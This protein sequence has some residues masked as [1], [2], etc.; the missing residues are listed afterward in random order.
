MYFIVNNRTKVKN[1]FFP[2]NIFLNLHPLNYTKK[3]SNI[4][5]IT[6][7]WEEITKAEDIVLVA[8]INPDG[9]AIGSLMGMK[10]YLETMGKRVTPIVP[11]PYPEFLSFLDTQKEV[12]AHSE[13]PDAVAAKVEAAQL[14]ICMD[15]NALKRIDNLGDVIAGASAV[16]A[17][18]DHHPQPDTK[19]NIVYSYPQMSST[20][21]L[22]YWIIQ[23][24]MELNG[25]TM[26]LHSAIA[27]YTGMMT[28]T[29]NFGNSV[30]P[31]TFKMAAG[32]MEAG[33]DKEWIQ[34]MVFGGYSA[35][36][37]RL[38]GY[39]LHENMKLIPEHNAAIMVLT[40]AI[41]EKYNFSDGDSEGFVNLALNIKSVKVS[42]L[43][44]EGDEFLRV[45][46]RS[47]DDFSVNRLSRAFFNGGGHERA[48][49]GRLY[50]PAGEV[51]EYFIKS[52]NEFAQMEKQA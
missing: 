41:K 49:G 29:N 4:A 1:I 2:C 23:D 11:N 24:L 8:H 19:F 9:D 6:L 12:M 5:D 10:G 39:M 21:E 13:N 17:L 34:K 40:K 7:L 14:I 31:S 44:T 42:A 15:F 47:K 46:L 48:A 30:L 20:C 38:M 33:V 27:L 36:R 16:K 52:L 22:A 50:I 25:N 28:D 32:L 18:I 3:V 51:E 37:M 26:P 43:F 45:S 35:D